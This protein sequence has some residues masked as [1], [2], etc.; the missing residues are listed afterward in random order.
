MAAMQILNDY[1]DRPYVLSI[2]KEDGPEPVS[3][4]Y[5]CS[6][7]TKNG[8]IYYLFLFREHRDATCANWPDA[9]KEFTG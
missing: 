2:S 4:Y 6:M 9:R 8:R 7:V 3:G 5:P 1:R